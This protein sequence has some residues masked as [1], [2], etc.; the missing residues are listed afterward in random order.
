[1]LK[2]VK[3]LRNENYSKGVYAY[4]LIKDGTISGHVDADGYLCYDDEE[5]EKHY[6][7][8]KRGRPIKVI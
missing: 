8:A 2:R 6:K 5:L 4:K 3:D 1:M 7:T